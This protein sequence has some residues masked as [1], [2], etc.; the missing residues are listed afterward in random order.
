[1]QILAVIAAI[2]QAAQYV[3]A[4][5]PLLQSLMQWHRDGKTEVTQEELDALIQEVTDLGKKKGA[6]Y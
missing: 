3:P 4:L 1:M 2:A 5:A 6:D